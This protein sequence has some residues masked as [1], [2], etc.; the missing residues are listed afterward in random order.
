M[1]NSGT[2]LQAE[3]LSMVCKDVEVEPVMQDISREGLNRG[4]NTTPDALL[5]IA[6]S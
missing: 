1:I 4:A 6:A 5:D 3:L 2:D